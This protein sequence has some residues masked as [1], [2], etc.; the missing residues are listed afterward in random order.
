MLARIATVAAFVSVALLAAP[1]AEAAHCSLIDQILG[2]CHEASEPTPEPT[3]EPPP[4][5]EP[6]ADPGHR[7][8]AAARILVLMNEERSARGLPPLAV[9][10]DVSA[11]SA[12]HSEDMAAKGTIWHNDAYFTAAVKDRLDARLLGENVARN[13]DIDDAHR[14][15]MNSPGHRANILDA[16]FTIVGLAVYDD[17]W[18]NLYVTQNFVQPAPPAPAQPVAGPRPGTVVPAV[19]EKPRS[20][21]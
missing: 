3:P 1:A 6:Q 19:A 8:A 9:R 16:R 11:I 5:P 7:P 12:P 2:Q 4:Q 10:P 15:L 13:T 21:P 18:G 14:R 20:A 17:G